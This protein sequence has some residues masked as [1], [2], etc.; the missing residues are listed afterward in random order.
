MKIEE[1]FAVLHITPGRSVSIANQPMSA[2]VL[3]GVSS[4][5]SEKVNPTG[6]TGIVFVHQTDLAKVNRFDARVDVTGNEEIK[7]HARFQPAH[8][9]DGAV[10]SPMIHEPPI[11]VQHVLVTK[12]AI[13]HRLA[14]RAE[15]A[16]WNGDRFDASRHD[17]KRS[18]L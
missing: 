16:L 12:G 18:S 13:G 5:A 1:Q 7:P 6:V 17:L 3:S 11:G 14:E 9:R 10:A 8:V 2:R 4:H 15:D